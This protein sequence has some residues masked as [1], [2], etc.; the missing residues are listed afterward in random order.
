MGQ[1]SLEQ[2]REAGLEG[3]I[4]ASLEHGRWKAVK[5]EEGSK[6]AGDKDPA[7]RPEE[8]GTREP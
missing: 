6:G 2:S 4:K 3:E 1:V 7:V 8:E 5:L